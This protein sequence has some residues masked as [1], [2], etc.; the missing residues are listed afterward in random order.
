VNRAKRNKCLCF[1]KINI[2][3]LGLQQQEFKST[4]E[5]L[6]INE[7]NIFSKSHECIE[8]K[9]FPAAVR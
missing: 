6:R 8:L 2:G 9:R 7:E 1:S 4:T 3:V 5:A